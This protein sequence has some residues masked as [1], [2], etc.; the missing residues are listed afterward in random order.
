M[1]TIL[2][3]NDNPIIDNTSNIELYD[4]ADFLYEIILEN[5]TNNK[6]TDIF[7]LGNQDT[8]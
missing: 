6:Q 3:M 8:L 2:K 4:D 5:Y 1:P 7:N